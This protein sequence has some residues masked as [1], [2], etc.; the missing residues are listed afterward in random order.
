ML[1]SSG[2]LDRRPRRGPLRPRRRRQPPTDVVRD[3]QEREL[4]DMLRLHDCPMHDPQRQPNADDHTLQQLFRAHSSFVQQAGG[5]AVAAP[6]NRGDWHR[7]PAC[8]GAY[9]LMFARPAT[10][11]EVNCCRVPRS[12]GQ[13]AWQQ[14]A[15]VLLGSN[16]FLFVD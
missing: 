11:E 12:R 2:S 14:Y 1:A 4:H 13:A 9:L 15:Q 5:G 10:D 3:D 16:E 8:A 6:T 7:S